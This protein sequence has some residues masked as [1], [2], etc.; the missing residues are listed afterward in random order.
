MSLASRRLL[1]ARKKKPNLPPTP[2]GGVVKS[3]IAFVLKASVLLP[4]A[5]VVWLYLKSIGRADLFQPAVLSLTGLG[6][7]LQ[8]TLLLIFS[9]LVFI[10]APS[11]LVGVIAASYDKNRPT[12]GAPLLAMLLAVYAAW[13]PVNWYLLDAGKLCPWMESLFVQLVAHL[14]PLYL[15]YRIARDGRCGVELLTSVEG[16]KPLVASGLVVLRMSLAL[17]GS[18]WAFVAGVL[19]TRGLVGAAGL[20]GDGWQLVAISSTIVFGV[21]PGAI[22]LFEMSRHGVVQRAAWVGSTILFVEVCVVLVGTSLNAFPAGFLAMKAMGVVEDQ[23][24]DF[25]LRS[26]AE[27]ETYRQIGFDVRYDRTFRGYIRF[28]FGDVRL[29]CVSSFDPTDAGFLREFNRSSPVKTATS[30]PT[31]GCITIPKDE[32]R[33]VQRSNASATLA[34]CRSALGGPRSINGLCPD[35]GKLFSIK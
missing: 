18:A 3:V 25:L 2:V 35:A 28:Q 6:A 19:F 33:V 29:V 34:N 11:V 17:F 22:F 4:A 21:V 32:L 5:I 26:E 8:A 1:I 15:L 20:Q 12:R 30:L 27:G 24:R 23:P 7:L 16:K 13:V 14:A 9:I 31:T 10:S